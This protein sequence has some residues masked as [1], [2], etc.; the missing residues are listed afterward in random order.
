MLNVAMMVGTVVEL[1]LSL[2]S[3]L[4]VIALETLLVMNFPIHYLQMDF[5]MMKPTLLTVTMMVETAVDLV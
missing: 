5:V 3:V 1:V 2:N 4:N